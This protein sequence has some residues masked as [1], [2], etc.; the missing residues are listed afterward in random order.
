HELVRAEAERLP[1]RVGENDEV[2]AL[3]FAERRG[4]R[5]RRAHVDV[6]LLCGERVGEI[7]RARG[8]PLDVEHERAPGDVERR[9]IAIVLA[10]R[11][12]PLR[13][14]LERVRHLAADANDALEL[15][16]AATTGQL[17]LPHGIEA[18]ERLALE[19][20]EARARRAARI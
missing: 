1:R 13:L 5:A 20:A 11:V 16:L 15:D 6:E 3:H 2:E 9:P 14:E 7:A 10:K 4:K 12:R 19:Q 17:E 8:L 18:I